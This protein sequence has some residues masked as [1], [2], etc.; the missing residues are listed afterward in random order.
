MKETLP[1]Y[2]ENDNTQMYDDRNIAASFNEHFASVGCNLASK[3]PE[4]IDKAEISSFI[5]HHDSIFEFNE[6]TL[7]ELQSVVRSMKNV[8]P[9]DDEFPVGLIKIC[10]MNLV[11]PV[12]C[13]LFNL[14]L[15]KGVFPDIL[16]SAKIATVHKG[17]SPYN[18]DNYRPV[19]VLKCLSSIFEKLVCDRL[20]VYL[21]CHKMLCNNQFL[22]RSGRSTEG[23]AGCC[24]VRLRALDSGSV[25][26]G[27]FPDLSKAFDSL[28]RD[29]LIFKLSKYGIIN[30]DLAWFKSYLTN[31]I[32]RT[33]WK[34]ELSEPSHVDFGIPQGSTVGPALFLLYINDLYCACQSSELVLFADDTNLFLSADSCDNLFD[35]CNL[36]LSTIHRW[37]ILNELT[38]NKAKTHYIVF[39]TA[40]MK[41]PENDRHIL[42]LGDYVIEMKNSTKFLR[43]TLD[44]NLNWMPHVRD[45]CRNWYQSIFSF[46]AV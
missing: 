1:S 41:L 44:K 20:R 38:I 23:I 7:R 6:L 32:I 12:L 4:S 45:V 15:A 35:T 26:L 16:K 27:V 22:F 29:V 42:R 40:H 18:K 13:S 17:G 3:F 31:S 30:W 28:N 34:G 37:F 10:N 43:V 19:S 11:L 21:D 25:A 5:P 33:K 8:S 39:Q 46:C 24:L 14:S 36:E 9:G 2:I